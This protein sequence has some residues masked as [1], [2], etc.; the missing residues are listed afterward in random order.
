MRLLLG[1]VAIA[2]VFTLAAL[3][4]PCAPLGLL[5]VSAWFVVGGFLSDRSSRE[6]R[7]KPEAST[8]QN[9]IRFV[10]E[11]LPGP[12]R[13][14]MR[15]IGVVPGHD[16]RLHDAIGYQTLNDG[17][18]QALATGTLMTKQVAPENLLFVFS[19]S[20][21]TLK[22]ALSELVNQHA[23]LNPVPY[24]LQVEDGRRQKGQHEFRA[25]VLCKLRKSAPFQ[26]ALGSVEQDPGYHGQSFRA[27]W[28]QVRELAQRFE[29]GHAANV[30]TGHFG[31][32]KDNK[33][34]S[35]G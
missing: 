23:L 9:K 14:A 34:A 18:R 15:E 21:Q 25:V 2:V 22:A 4:W 13:D 6:R 12:F 11:F 19:E 3:Q 16:R 33:D 26:H 30:I 24:A 17:V 28:E 20:A 8:Q 1:T 32:G 31:E 27:T 7:L 5:T 29:P 10:Y 35:H